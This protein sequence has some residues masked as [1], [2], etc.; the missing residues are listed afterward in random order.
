MAEAIDQDQVVPSLESGVDEVESESHD[1]DEVEV[2]VYK[3]FQ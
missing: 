2:D 3:Y 1:T